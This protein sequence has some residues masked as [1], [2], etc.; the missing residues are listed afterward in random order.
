MALKK[1]INLEVVYRSDVVGVE[2]IVRTKELKNAYISVVN[3]TGTKSSMSCVISIIDEKKQTVYQHKKYD[4][5]PDVSEGAENIY[6]QVY[7]YLK[8][9]DEFRDAEDVLEAGQYA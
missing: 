3:I 5:V 6:K 4:F 9:C 7:K 8:T 1:N 2:D